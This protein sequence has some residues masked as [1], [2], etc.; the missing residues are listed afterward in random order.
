MK[1]QFVG[2]LFLAFLPLLV[3]P[4][5]AA[6]I[7][8][9]TQNQYL[10]ADLTPIFTASDLAEVNAAIVTAL[11]T[12]AASKP[13]ERMKALASEIAK[14]KPAL[15]GLQEVYE[16]H[17]AD[18]LQ[19]PVQGYGCSDPSIAAAFSDQLQLTLDAL[20]GTYVEKAQVVNVNIIGVPFLINGVWAAVSVVDRD[21]ILARHGVAAT[22]VNYAAVCAKPSADGCNYSIVLSVPTLLGTI[23]LERGFVAVDA[24]VD[25]KKYRLVNT[26][27]EQQQLGPAN[28]L[29]QFYQAAQAGELLYILMNTTPL[30]RSLVVVGDMNSSPEHLAVLGPL[31]LPAPFDAGIPTPYQLFLVAGFTD[32][33]E[34]RPGRLP[35]YTCCQ[36]EDLVNHRSELYERVDMIFSYDVPSSV[37][38][39][40]V[41]GA[42]VSDKTRPQGR[43]LWP[44]DHASVT[45]DL[46]FGLLTAKK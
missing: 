42:T 36:Q 40:R 22:P 4:A 46:Q 20:D 8:L 18:L 17:C 45:A 26:H 34:L 14:E 16:F 37:K 31:P 5:G 6:G 9:M 29:F 30:D 28:P 15:V 10:G 12:V 39:A 1:K 43:G 35:G 27:L 19:P 44:S 11:Q 33:W 23:S 13:G 7:K 32:T 21:V 38:R 24:T 3:M 25:G 2:I 41:V